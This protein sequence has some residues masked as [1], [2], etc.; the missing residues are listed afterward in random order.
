MAASL[1]LLPSMVIVVGT[2]FRRP[3][4][5]VCH[6]RP[7]GTGPHRV[8]HGHS[9]VP[10]DGDD[11]LA[12]G[13]RGGAGAGGEAMIVSTVALQAVMAGG[14]PPCLPGRR[15]EPAA[16]GLSPDGGTRPRGR[17]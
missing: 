2:P 15:G 7:A 12:A 14:H 17:V 13:G 3:R 10:V 16:Q 1:A 8:T 6:A 5:A 9:D 4:H 11:V